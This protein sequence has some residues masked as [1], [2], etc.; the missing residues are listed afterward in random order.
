[1][2]LR[3]SWG[4]HRDGVH[5]VLDMTACGGE[6]QSAVAANPGGVISYDDLPAGIQEELEAQMRDGVRSLLASVPIWLFAITDPIRDVPDY[7]AILAFGL[8]KLCV[9]E[10]VADKMC[11]VSHRLDLEPGP[12]IK[13]P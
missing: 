6:V 2:R 9:P 13:A 4:D 5:L 3:P 12:F 10:C 1:M 11:V 7:Q 8:P